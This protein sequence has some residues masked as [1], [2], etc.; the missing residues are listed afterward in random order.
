MHKSQLPLSHLSDITIETKRINESHLRHIILLPYPNQLPKNDFFLSFFIDMIHSCVD[1]AD[2][3]QL[4][5][6]E[7]VQQ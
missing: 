7:L 2:V 3:H 6:S 4:F 5:V 1:T